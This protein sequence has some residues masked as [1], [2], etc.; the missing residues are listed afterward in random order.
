MSKL[1]A[2][3]TIMLTTATQG[4]GRRY[5]LP[6]TA[7]TVNNLLQPYE[8]IF[9]GVQTIPQEL[10]VRQDELFL[11]LRDEPFMDHANDAGNLG[12]FFLIYHAQGVQTTLEENKLV[13]TCDVLSFVRCILPYRQD[14]L[15]DTTYIDPRFIT[16][17]IS[18]FTPVG[19]NV[20]LGLHEHSIVKFTDKDEYVCVYR[21]IDTQHRIQKNTESVVGTGSNIA[22]LQEMKRKEVET[23]WHTQ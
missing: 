4:E 6:L 1:L 10:R 2:E 17:G 12:H 19:G 9:Y 15:K 23:L 13:M 5:I 22:Q 18:T 16:R 21:H 11:A 20:R 7:F 14:P 8:L 3:E